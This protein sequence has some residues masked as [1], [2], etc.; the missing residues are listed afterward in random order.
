[1]P[2]KAYLR[3][4]ELMPQFLNFCNASVKKRFVFL[5]GKEMKTIL[6]GLGA[7]TRD[8]DILQRAGSSLPPDPTLP[9]RRAQMGRWVFDQTNQ[10]PTLRRGEHQP[11]VLS[12][13]EDFV[14][15]DS[16][17]VRNFDEVPRDLNNNTALQALLAF[18]LFMMQG[19]GE[20][21]AHR[22]S[23]DYSSPKY[24]CTAVPIRTTTTATLVGE[25]ALE[26]VHAD[27]VDFTMTTFLNAT[28]VTD[29]NAQTLLHDNR[30]KNALAHC[31]TDPKYR[32]AEYQ[33][34][35]YLDTLLFF[36]HELKHSLSSVVPADKS[37]DAHRDMIVFVTRKPT[38]EG[39][40]R[41]E[42]DSLKDHKEQP[43]SITLGPG[44]PVEVNKWNYP[45]ISPS[46][47]PS[48]LEEGRRRLR[49][50]RP[51]YRAQL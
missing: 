47:L 49:S 11:W 16:G 21:Y 27:G 14:R 48:R 10:P 23:L 19:A 1:M 26:G 46:S 40:I 25:P 28:N 5:P 37:K 22:P 36:D 35:N 2:H 34:R 4:L 50:Q 51:E 42:R 38:L 30:Q 24:V 15:H 7:K 43:L 9:F 45:H 32:V 39:D 17:Q 8:M 20:N 13:A 6:S 33:H 31:D 3:S 29:N 41:F 12:D 44:L 18:K